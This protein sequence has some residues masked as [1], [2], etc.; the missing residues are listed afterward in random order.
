[1]YIPTDDEADETL[2]ALVDKCLGESFEK[3]VAKKVEAFTSEVHDQLHYGIIDDLRANLRGEI[4]SEARR[5]AEDFMLSLANGAER[6]VAQFLD[7]PADYYNER[8]RH[9]DLL[10]EGREYG[11]MALRKKML[12]SVLPQLEVERIK[13]LEAKAEARLL[14]YEK[15]RDELLVA[16]RT[17]DN[18]G[19]DNALMNGRIAHLE[20]ELDKAKQKP[21]L[22]VVGQ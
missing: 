20:R 18:L 1:M 11:G 9:H 3:A 14:A 17:V 7:L 19:K 22:T 6:Q 5:L 8:E 21:S 15:A 16:R 12:E 10:E 2:N 13:D 4:R